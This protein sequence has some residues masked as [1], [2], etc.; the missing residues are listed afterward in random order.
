MTAH[1]PGPWELQMAEDCTG[2]KLDDLV[3]WVVTAKEHDLWISTG[4]TWDAEHADESNANAR[5]IAAAP[6]LLA[7]LE[8]IKCLA[9][10]GTLFRVDAE[11][12]I[13]KAKGKQP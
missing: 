5:L 11:A 9:P 8:Q 7:A 3:R 2:R 4:P 13:A 12:A 10:P 1:T 6:E